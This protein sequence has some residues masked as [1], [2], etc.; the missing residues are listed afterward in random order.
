MIKFLFD[1]CRDFPLVGDAIKV[2]YVGS[3]IKN[4]V[5][6]GKQSK[7]AKDLSNLSGDELEGAI[8]DEANNV[9]DEFIMPEI[10]SYNFPEAVI[11]P[12]KEKAIEQI[13]ANIKE[14]V[15]KKAEQKIGI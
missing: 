8:N 11:S 12:M 1:Y 5:N 2:A 10:S 7:S 3:L 13:S 4:V 14:K 15:Q 6:E 9:F